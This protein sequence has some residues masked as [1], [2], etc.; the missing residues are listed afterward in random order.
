[1]AGYPPPTRF[2][3]ARDP[4]Q[5]QPNP[6]L[7]STRPWYPTNAMQDCCC[8]KDTGAGR[9]RRGSPVVHGDAYAGYLAS[10]YSM[11]T[12]E[13]DSLSKSL[14]IWSTVLYAASALHCLPME[15]RQCLWSL[16]R[17]AQASETNFDRWGTSNFTGAQSEVYTMLDG[18]LQKR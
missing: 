11:S 16:S 12:R 18:S 6:S 15:A 3:R 8:W 10:Y 9:A 7:S 5:T 2:S 1:M 13:H 14:P 17:F 4:L